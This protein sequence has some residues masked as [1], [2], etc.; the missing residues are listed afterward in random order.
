M[1]IL[2]WGVFDVGKPRTR[3]L[4]RGIETTGAEITE[5][6][7]PIWTGIEDKSQVRGL[8]AKLWLLVRWLCSYP[9]ILYRF[10]RGPRP[11][12]VVI[13]YP[14]LIDVLVLAPFAKV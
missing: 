9:A 12:I 5:C 13:G 1:R 7:S 3:I 8:W 11:D 4:R 2:F 10:M 6:H 14:G